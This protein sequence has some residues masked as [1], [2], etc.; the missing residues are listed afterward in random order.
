M[1]KSTFKRLVTQRFRPM[2]YCE[3]CGLTYD[4]VLQEPAHPHRPLNAQR[5][6]EA[7]ERMRIQRGN[8][9]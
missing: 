9:G 8:R 4:P 2:S 7:V 5:T 3:S 1:S 6:S